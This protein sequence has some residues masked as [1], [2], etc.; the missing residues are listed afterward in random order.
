MLRTNSQEARPGCTVPPCELQ[1]RRALERATYEGIS[2]GLRLTSLSLQ[3]DPKPPKVGLRWEFRQRSAVFSSSKPLHSC[4]FTPKTLLFLCVKDLRAP[5]VWPG[6]RSTTISQRRQKPP[7]DAGRGSAPDW[8][9]QGARPSK[10]GRFSLRQKAA[11]SSPTAAARGHWPSPHSRGSPTPSPRGERGRGGAARR[12]LPLTIRWERRCA[13]RP[14]Q[15]PQGR[16]PAPTLAG[17]RA[18]ARPI[19]SDAPAGSRGSGGT[20]FKGAEAPPS[21][22]PQRRRCGKAA[23]AA[24]TGSPGL[25]AGGV[26]GDGVG[27]AR[28]F[29]SHLALSE[30]GGAPGSQHRGIE[31][32]SL[33][34]TQCGAVPSALHPVVR[35]KRFPLPS[36]PVPRPAAPGWLLSLSLSL[37]SVWR[38]PPG[39]EE[40]GRKRP[41]VPARPFNA[42]GGFV[43][44]PAALGCAR[45]GQ[46]AEDSRPGQWEA[47]G[48]WSRAFELL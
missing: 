22:F 31:R 26:R 17:S 20:V 8:P 12:P 43:R 21:L 42:P 18:P 9:P 28:V 14:P 40:G 15:A 6:Q 23:A 30:P 47:L 3:T 45:R 35:H 41:K 19:N 38:G 27:P 4:Y 11:P 25:P 37:R 16:P 10:P 1:P 46:E 36:S 13:A 29:P 32:L 39:G 33:T 2:V 24:P 7:R 48:I 5:R 34:E 44:W